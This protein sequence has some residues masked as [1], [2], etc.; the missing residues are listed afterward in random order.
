LT[1]ILLG[2]NN[3]RHSERFM[4][5]PSGEPRAAERAEAALVYATA[6]I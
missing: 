5:T 3:D 1:V 2:F 4:T 6:T